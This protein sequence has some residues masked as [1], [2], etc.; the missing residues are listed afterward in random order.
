MQRPKKRMQ[1]W[2]KLFATI[3][4]AIF[5]TMSFRGGRI[6]AQS[7]PQLVGRIEGDDVEVVTTTPSGTETNA[8]PTVV[9]S[10]SEVTLRSGQAL[11][12][13]NSGGTISICGPAHFKMLK[14]AGAVTLALDYGRVHPALNSA[15][16]FTI[17]TPTII[18][19]PIA[20]S[21]ARRD[22]TIGLEESGEMCAVTTR[23]AMRMEPQFSEQ[24]LI[25]PQGG[26]ATLSGGQIETLSGDASSCTCDFQRAG[27]DPQRASPPPREI[28]LLHH[29]QPTEKK[30]PGTPPPATEPDNA[31]AYTVV[32]PA[33]TYDANSPAMPPDPDPAT[34]LLVR[35]VRVQAP[36]FF[37]GH[38]NPAPAP[39]G[40]ASSATPTP[41]EP[42][43]PR[44]AQLQPGFWD[45][46]RNFFRKL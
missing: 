1:M 46:V 29:T 36:A 18:A 33:L 11:L 43:A 2:L 45:R 13:L 30:K 21:G 22:L 17:F 8:A 26:A 25:L 9:A 38:V 7:L 34:I 10:G 32:M 16:V 35:E 28:S 15:E 39:V 5:V 31:P 44:E 42:E 14:S 41:A 12:L 19:T 27:M 3:L 23:G 20:I 4:L 40:V 24:G 6:S 37:R